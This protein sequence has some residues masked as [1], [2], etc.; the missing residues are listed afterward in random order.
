MGTPKEQLLDIERLKLDY[1]AVQLQQMWLLVREREEIHKPLCAL[2][3]DPTLQLTA[4]DFARLYHAGLVRR[5]EDK[6]VVSSVLLASYFRE[7]C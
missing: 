4:D 7:R 6:Y 1:C 5:D 3:K 2:L